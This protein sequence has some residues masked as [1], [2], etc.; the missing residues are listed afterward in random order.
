MNASS[1][2]KLLILL[3]T[4]VLLLGMLISYFCLPFTLYTAVPKSRIDVDKEQGIITASENDIRILQLTDLHV[5]GKLE[6]P[7]VFSIMKSAIMK[8]EPDLIVITGDVFS[9]RCRKEDVKTLCDFMARIGIPWAAVLGNHDDETPYSL[10]ELSEILENSEGSLFKRGNLNEKYGNYYYYVKFPDGRVQQLIF[11]DSR[12]D[13]F[14]EESV[15][16]YENAVLDSARFDGVN[17]VENLLFYHIPVPELAD[18]VAAYEK[19]SSIGSGEI[20]EPSSLQSTSVGFF[21]KVLELQRTKAMIF[22]HDHYNNTII[23]Y[24]NVD[25]CY[26]TRTGLAGGHNSK[27]G[28]NLFALKSDGNY[29]IKRLIHF[30]TDSIHSR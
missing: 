30:G 3:L 17:T 21:D 5:N 9:S 6:M 20:G 11:M 19:D 23:N 4:V 10:D 14:T 15:D 7:M 13:G 18:A 26:G 16:F 22:G 28:G 8:S 27:L 1:G 2:K 29:T 24:C 25:F 12:S